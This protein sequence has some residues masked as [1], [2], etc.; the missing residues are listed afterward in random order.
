MLFDDGENILESD[1]ERNLYYKFFA[2]YFFNEFIIGYQN[3]LMDFLTLLQ[4][5]SEDDNPVNKRH[6]GKNIQD[7]R[8][9]PN[10]THITFDFHAYLFGQK[11]RGEL[12]DILV[13][14]RQNKFLIALEVKPLQP[15][16]VEKDVKENQERLREISSD[17]TIIQCLLV[18]EKAWKNI[19]ERRKRKNSSYQKL[20]DWESQNPKIPLKVLL[21]QDFL[22]LCDNSSVRNY[23]KEHLT[24]DKESYRRHH[25]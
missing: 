20:K 19:I 5:N 15:L 1:K 6:F 17:T 21:W 12:A 11:N 2:G 14:D 13:H 22:P 23:L 7:I 4:S 9:S 25:L 18:N 10:F 24:R 8:I 3:R 16:R